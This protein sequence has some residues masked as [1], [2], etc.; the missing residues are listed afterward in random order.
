MPNPLTTRRSI[1]KFLPT[2]VSPDAIRAIVAVAAYAP[3]WKNS[4]TTRYTLL[5]G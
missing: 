1:R 2:P 3:S 4:Q 5:S